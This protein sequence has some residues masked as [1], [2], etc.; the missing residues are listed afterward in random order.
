MCAL[1]R[2]NFIVWRRNP[3]CGFFELLAPVVMM[4]CL[5]WIRTLVPIEDIS[6]D[7]RLDAKFASN[8]G[9]AN[10]GGTWSSSQGDN[11]WLNDKLRPMYIFAN[12]TDKHYKNASEY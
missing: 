5:W 2:K 6:K 3:F 1:L 11:A 12:Y 7:G 10:L 8:L 4:S 9:I